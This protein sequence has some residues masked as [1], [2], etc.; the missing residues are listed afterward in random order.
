MELH[1]LTTKFYLTVPFIIETKLFTIETLQ[2]KCNQSVFKLRTKIHSG[3]RRLIF[4][5]AYFILYTITKQANRNK[6]VLVGHLINVIK[7]TL[8]TLQ[9][10]HIITPELN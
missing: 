7:L 9:I 1:K 5:S 3:N 4:Y 8:P 6:M 10:L 2:H